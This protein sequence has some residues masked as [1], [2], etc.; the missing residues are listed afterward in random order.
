MRPGTAAARGCRRGLGVLGLAAGFALLPRL[1]L[2][3]EC[4]DY[5]EAM[6]YVG[7]V[8]TPGVRAWAVALSKGYAF[9]VDGDFQ[10]VDISDPASPSLA[11]SAWTPDWA[12]DVA[13]E[14]DYAYVAD[15]G[16]GLQVIDV[17][18]PSAPSIAGSVDTPGEAQGVAVA[19][20]Y[21][22]VADG[23]SGLQVIDVSNP[24]AP[25]IVGSLDTP[26]SAVDIAVHGSHAYVGHTR[27][28][29][30]GWGRLQIIDVGNP[31][32]P[33]LVSTIGEDGA[34]MR[35][36]A[37]AERGTPPQP[38]LYV[39]ATG[40]VAGFYIVDVSN[41][42]SPVILA[43]LT[44]G[45]GTEVA[46]S[47]DWAYELSGA[48]TAIDVSDPRSPRVTGRV[49]IY[50]AYGVAVSGRYVYLAAD[51][52]GL[53]VIDVSTPKGPPQLIGRVNFTSTSY[54][55][56]VAG[57]YAYLA[58][59]EDGLVI[60]D[61]SNPRSPA[62]AGTLPVYGSS[63]VAVAG[64]YAYTNSVW[65]DLFVVDV[66]DPRNPLVV[67]S[68]RPVADFAYAVDG[69]Y[70][71][72]ASDGPEG[73]VIDVVDVSDPTAP[74]LLSETVIPDGPHGMAVAGAYLYVADTWGGF[75]VVDVSEPTAP[76]VVATV[77]WEYP[78]YV[79]S[80]AVAG[81]YAY[82]GDVWLGE[83]NNGRLRV[84]DISDPLSPVPVGMVDFPGGG[85]DV[86]IRGTL[87]YVAAF[88]VG[89]QVI[90]ISDPR[91]PRL[92]GVAATT[93]GGAYSGAYCIAL[94][95]CAYLGQTRGGLR[96][97][98]LH[99][100]ATSSVANSPD[101]A[102]PPAVLRV[103]PNPA[104]GE[105]GLAFELLRGG[106]A[107]LEI[108]DVGGHL[109]RRLVDGRVSGGSPRATWDRRN[110]R[111]GAVAAGTYLARLSWPGGATVQRVTLLP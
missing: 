22:Y 75:L 46:V 40:N 91:A 11:G 84:I 95:D 90:D 42:A 71:Y 97:L 55:V 3:D 48:L 105:P 81:T 109:V 54:D 79:W 1:V 77:P 82:V 2:G 100:P 14:G 103:W 63:V 35:G 73:G 85:Y 102:T 6:H 106:E 98:P 61:V 39:V 111:G 47:G 96:I 37:V 31:A 99:C 9:V 69:S 104:R 59:G 56:A 107:R 17:S 16:S 29:G 108:Y 60:I 26:G 18:V 38:L 24:G 68:L 21:A 28:V 64:S 88:E 87:A 36:V 49:P 70:L 89:M 12:N 52:N 8:L 19:G 25:V 15:G 45:G 20:T 33:K 53:Q 78:F 58:Q 27:G 51:A 110:D 57:D 92:V 62:V 72:G 101:E 76:R 80:V 23:E 5:G 10:V 44:E 41:P 86:A 32:S 13:A 93:T 94:A 7:G 74:V 83:A 67:G 30:G 4:V 50:S 43:N 65:G 34:S 66:S